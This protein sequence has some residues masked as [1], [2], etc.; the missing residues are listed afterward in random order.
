M[1]LT[2]RALCAT[3][4]GAAAALSAGGALAQVPAGYPADYAALIEA[5]KKEGSVVVYSTT[6]AKAAGPLIKDFET[7]Y[8]IKVE[9]NDLNSTELYNRVIAESASGQGTADLAWSSAPDLQIKLA[10]D[11]LEAAPGDLELADGQSGEALATFRAAH[12][13]ARSPRT[14]ARL[15]SSLLEVL[16]RE[17][18]DK[19]TLQSELDALAERE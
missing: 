8:G 19:P 7:L 9:Y 17:G 18:A 10:A 1:T 2:R 5:A 16:S 3:I 12:A 13:V 6:D 14:R 15:T 4:F 11:K